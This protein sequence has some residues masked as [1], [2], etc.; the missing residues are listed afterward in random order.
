MAKD[1]VM[2]KLAMAMNEGT[3]NEWF[4]SEGDYVEK[5]VELA[6]IETEKVAYDVEAPEAGYLHIIVAA[7]ET[8]D[9]EVL[10]AQFAESEEELLSLQ[11]A[12]TAKEAESKPPEKESADSA[13]AHTAVRRAP[14]ERIKAS[15]LARKLAGKAGLDLASI[16][17]TGPG[18]RIVKRDILAAEAQP[19]VA[20]TVG[21]DEITR[22]PMKG[23]RAGIARRM[24]DSL[25]TAAQ[26]ASNWEADVTDLMDVR[27][28][29]VQRQEELGTRVSVNA[30]L[31]KA[32]VG[33]V[34][35]VPIANAAI[36]GDDIVIYQS[37]HMGIAV[38][39]PGQ[40]EYD[41]TL[42]VPVLRDV[43]QLTVVD[44]DLRMKALVEKARAG[45]LGADELSGSTITLSST[46]GIAPPGLAT[47]PILN[48]PN[49]LIVGPSTPIERPVVYQGEI[50]PRTMLPISATFDH[51][52]L[53][54][55]PFAR[56]AMALTD[57]LENPELL[58]A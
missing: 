33:A 41:S 31:I 19:A 24:V 43:D 25:Q 47:A 57:R 3:I 37:V 18:G 51:R 46:A 4:F 10:V 58:L 8:V 48:L 27:Q 45:T 49:A 9:C 7:G 16:D 54:G 36:D 44:I 5:G 38:A 14:G 39:L 34:R 32:I 15:P 6:S 11:S 23:V 35:Q 13:A 2:P 56:F 21:S 42:V 26:L 22:I 55:E 28:R 17:G 53:D 52:V 12:G 40:T 50:V 29:L 1:Y 20:A 30:L